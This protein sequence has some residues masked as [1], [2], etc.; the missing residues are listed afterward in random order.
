MKSI[1]V[2]L[3]TSKIDNLTISESLK[4]DFGEFVKNLPN[5]KS[6]T[7]EYVKMTVFEIEALKSQKNLFHVKS[8]WQKVQCGNSAYVLS[9]EFYVK[10]MFSEF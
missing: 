6:R 2:N 7:S 9:L 10:S 5:T 1:L 3:N 8:E 4:Q